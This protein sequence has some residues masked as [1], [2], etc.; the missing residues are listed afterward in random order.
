M[1]D[2]T[3]AD[4]TFLRELVDSPYITAGNNSDIKYEL[5]RRSHQELILTYTEIYHMSDKLI[6]DV[7]VSDVRVSDGTVEEVGNELDRR[8]MDGTYSLSANPFGWSQA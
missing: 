4:E 7:L 6:H 5:A 2:L 3:K 8:I 1:I